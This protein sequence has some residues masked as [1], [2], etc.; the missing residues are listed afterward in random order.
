[1]KHYKLGEI[2]KI[3]FFASL[4]WRKLQNIFGEHCISILAKVAAASAEPS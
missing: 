4:F 2:C 1:M 3:M